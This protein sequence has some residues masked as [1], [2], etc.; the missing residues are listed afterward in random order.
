M[1][2]MERLAL[3][4]YVAINV[5]LF[6]FVYLIAYM[7]PAYEPTKNDIYGCFGLG[8]ALTFI[9]WAFFRAIDFMLGGPL[10]RELKLMSR[11]N[12]AKSV[13]GSSTSR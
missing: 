1:L 9:V 6:G 10:R 4:F 7:A 8:I 13:G 5:F 11:I 2:W 12:S 3:M